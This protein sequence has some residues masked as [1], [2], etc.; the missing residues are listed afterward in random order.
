M[1]RLVLPIILILSLVT[2]LVLTGCGKKQAEEQQPQQAMPQNMPPQ[3]EMHSGPSNAAAGIHWTVPSAWQEQGQR[4]MRVATYSIPAAGGQGDPGECAVFFF[5]RGEG[6]DVEANIS[7]WVSQFEK[8]GEAQRTS[9]TVDGMAVT[10]VRVGGTY[11]APSGPMM[12]SSGKKEGYKLLGAIIAA[13]EGSVFFKF[14]G[15]A[16]VVDGAE[17]EFMGMI[18]TIAK[19]QKAS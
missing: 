15:P 16:K 4:A 14:T 19:I 5:G 2:L 1:R 13:P 6:G 18:D 3:Q 8:P 11:L 10:M 9:K 7:R 12:Q 17:K